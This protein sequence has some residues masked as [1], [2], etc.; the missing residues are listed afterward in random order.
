M[1]IK[2][3][4]VS[5]R[6]SK[7]YDILYKNRAVGKLFL[8]EDDSIVRIESLHIEKRYRKKGFGRAVID[9]LKE[10]Y[11]VISGCSSPFA[12]KFW[13]NV[14]AKFEYEI[15]D[16]DNDTIYELLSMG[17]YPAFCIYSKNIDISD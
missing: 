2:L 12:I 8:Y 3:H 14:G 5:K 10:D 4:F 6:Y 15:E 16:I 9:K 17:E 13:L 7:E 1:D 11:S